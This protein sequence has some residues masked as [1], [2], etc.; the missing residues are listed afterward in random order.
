MGQYRPLFCLFSF[1]SRYN[2][3][4]NWKKR[5]WCAWDSNPGPQD[6]RRRWNHG[7][8]AATPNFCILTSVKSHVRFEGTGA[9]KSNW[10]HVALDIAGLA[11]VGPLVRF[12][13]GL[14]GELFPTLV[15]RERFLA[16][17]KVRRSFWLNLLFL[18]TLKLEF[19]K[20]YI[21]KILRSFVLCLFCRL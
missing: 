3:N 20:S 15:T 19:F 10:A 5:R 16:W 7:A 8:M 1:F 9:G 18:Q 2:F 12:Q 14:D 13:S 17:N 6:G 4:I 11:V 21:Q